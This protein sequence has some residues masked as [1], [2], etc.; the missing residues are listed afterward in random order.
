[1]YAYFALVPFLF[2]I[3]IL[4]ASLGAFLGQK[5]ADEFFVFFLDRR[6]ATFCHFFVTAELRL[7]AI[8]F[9]TADLRLIGIFP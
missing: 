4:G 3:H 8:F 1:M 6:P 5:L 2:Q 9:V 7:F